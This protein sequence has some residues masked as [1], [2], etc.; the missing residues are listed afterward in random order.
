MFCIQAAGGPSAFLRRGAPTADARVSQAAVGWDAEGFAEGFIRSF[1][2]FV[3]FSCGFTWFYRFLIELL[4]IF[5]NV[6][7][8]T[9]KDLFGHS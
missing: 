8:T 9:Y 4:V 6:D 7:L 3:F 2:F 1:F 5:Q